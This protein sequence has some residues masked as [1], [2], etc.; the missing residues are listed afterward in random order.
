MYIYIVFAYMYMRKHFSTA[1]SIT[2]QSFLTAEYTTPQL[3]ALV[4]AVFHVMANVM[5]GKAGMHTLSSVGPTTSP[6][7]I[8]H[9]FPL[10]HMIILLY[11]RNTVTCAYT[12]MCRGK[13]Y[14]L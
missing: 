2:V 7:G 12:C 11:M 9:F 14:M 8:L 10:Y 5:G 3:T 13:M 1:V 4:I 6:S